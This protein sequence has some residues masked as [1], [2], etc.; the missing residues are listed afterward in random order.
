MPAVE[1]IPVRSEAQIAS[2]EKLAHEIWYEYYVP[3]IGQ[4]QVDYMVSKFQS[5]AAMR[6]QIRAGYEYF[7]M[8]RDAALLGYMA[9]QSQ[10]AEQRLFISKLYLHRDARGTGTG[11]LAMEFIERLARDR[12]LPL[13]WL[14]V[15]KGNPAVK[16]YQRL[17]FRIEAPVVMDIGNG[18]VMDDFRMEKALL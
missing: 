7:T 8:E 11:R 15:N 2:V 12:R 5:A 6:E 18:F 13:L 14:T 3:L 10:P 9:V 1:F 17:G 16:T 4:S